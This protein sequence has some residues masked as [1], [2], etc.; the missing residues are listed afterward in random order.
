[1]RRLL[2]PVVIA[3]AI[4]AALGIVLG[5]PESPGPVPAPTP[6]VSTPAPLP[7]ATGI[8]GEGIAEGIDPAQVQPDGLPSDPQLLPDKVQAVP[9]PGAGANALEVPTE[10]YGVGGEIYVSSPAF[11]KKQRLAA[12]FY[13]PSGSL[14]GAWDV[15]IWTGTKVYAATDGTIVGKRDGVRNNPPGYNPGSG[16]A[17]NWLLL[18][19]DSKVLYYQHLSPGIDVKRGAKVKRGQPLGES[20]NSGNST[21]PHLH[22]SASTSPW[23]CKNI[24]QARAES[25][26]YRYLSKPSAR[27]FAPSKFWAKPAAK[28]AVSVAAAAKACRSS[29]SAENFRYARKGLG[30]RHTATNG[31]GPAARKQIRK[32]QRELG[33]RGKAADGIPGR[34]SLTAIC[35]R[36]GCKVV[37]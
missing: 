36:G 4:I 35:K 17:S 10:E 22:L 2:A 13:Y 21:G 20:G 7:P 12:G 26:R 31:C 32:V 11:K 14:H 1:M 5:L 23:A 25:I 34:Q 29:K 19:K 24:T 8:D 28:P 15:G 18:C 6:T 37:S 30:M 16:A 9:D 33:Y 27:I 3:L